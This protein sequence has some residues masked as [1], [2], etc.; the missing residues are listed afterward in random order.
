MSRLLRSLPTGERA[1]ASGLLALLLLAAAGPPLADVTAVDGC[2]TGAWEDGCWL[3]GEK[4]RQRLHREPD[5]SSR[6]RQ[7]SPAFEAQAS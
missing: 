5:E 6:H 4:G 1:L 7:R 3:L 2:C